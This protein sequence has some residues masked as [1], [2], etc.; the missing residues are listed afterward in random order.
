MKKKGRRRRKEEGEEEDEKRNE[1]LLDVFTRFATV[2]TPCIQTLD[3]TIKSPWHRR[4]AKLALSR[5]MG[6]SV[7]AMGSKSRITYGTGVG[8]QRR[9]GVFFLC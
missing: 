1:P 9:V 7:R 2:P 5:P 4:K 3:Q 6:C 8:G